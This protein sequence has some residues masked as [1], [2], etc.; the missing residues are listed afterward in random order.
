MLR[1][2][3][4]R[5]ATHLCY[6]NAGQRREVSGR[7]VGPSGRSLQV[8]G[9]EPRPGRPQHEGRKAASWQSAARALAR[10]SKRTFKL[11]LLSVVVGPSAKPV[12]KEGHQLMVTSAKA[13]RPY[14]PTSQHLFTPGISASNGAARPERPVRPFCFKR[15]EFS[16]IL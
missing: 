15:N 16:I 10:R 1:C 2:R 8:R 5:S 11:G 3:I 12:A 4:P 14:F 9:E 13:T 7:D 6:S